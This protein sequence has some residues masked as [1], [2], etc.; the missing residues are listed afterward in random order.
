MLFCC[1]I[2]LY[3]SQKGVFIVDRS[4]ILSVFKD[5]P[6]LVT[7]R[8]LM[9]RLL[10]SDA[11]DMFEY[12]SDPEVTRFLLWEPHI[13]LRYTARYLSY[14]QGRYRSGEFYDWAVTDRY[15]GKM[16]GTCGFTSFDFPNN[17]AEVGYVLNPAFWHLGIAAEAL[18]EILHFGFTI[19][20]LNR[21]EAKYIL[22]NNDSRR[23]MEKVGMTFEGIARSSMFVKG[24]YASVG[25]CA[26]LR[27]DYLD[28][29]GPPQIC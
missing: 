3:I 13:S 24:R 5:P 9:R 12:A 26:I 28:F 17:S 6:I 18:C 8:L 25:T 4:E 7:E 23:V 29:S 15:S 20:G 11:E 21:I 19:L 27:S 2:N 22:G 16:I 1:I 14:L 10:K